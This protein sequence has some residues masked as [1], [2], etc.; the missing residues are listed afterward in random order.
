MT[1][2]RSIV[3]FIAVAGLGLV[4]LFGWWVAGEF[5]RN[6]LAGL[7]GP[8]TKGSS[9]AAG[10]SAPDRSSR[11]FYVGYVGSQACADCHADICETYAKHP[12]SNSMSL[13]HESPEISSEAESMSFV[14]PSSPDFDVRLHY[15]VT[16]DGAK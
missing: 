6:P 9:Q 7:E 15:E 2:S 14:A 12:M 3:P 5:F 16:R 8:E 13:P 1:R 10:D 11:E 4:V